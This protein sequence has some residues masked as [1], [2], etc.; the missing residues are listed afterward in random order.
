MA[1]YEIFSFEVSSTKEV[2]A[3]GIAEAMFDYLPWPTLDVSI[4]WEASNGIYMVTDNSTG[5]KYKV[6][7]L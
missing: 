5:F 6:Q 1:R 3:P 2:E 7:L 4:H